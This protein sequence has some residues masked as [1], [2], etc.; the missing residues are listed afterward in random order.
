[1][2]KVSNQRKGLVIKD[3]RKEVQ[4]RNNP[5]EEQETIIIVDYHEKTISIYSSRKAVCSRF[6]E[7]FGESKDIFQWSG[8]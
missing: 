7:M 1:M 2:I 8:G 4:F 5:R 3:I 6:Y